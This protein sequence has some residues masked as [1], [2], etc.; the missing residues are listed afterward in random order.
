LRGSNGISMIL[1]LDGQVETKIVCPNKA[2]CSN[3][4]ALDI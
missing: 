2:F 4:D 1:K 3:Y